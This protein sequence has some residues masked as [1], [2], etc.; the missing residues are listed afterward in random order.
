MKAPR[1]LQAIEN[2]SPA[3]YP[4][5]EVSRDERV[6]RRLFSSRSAGERKELV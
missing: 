5:S 4:L 3:T 6:M 2:Q 1:R